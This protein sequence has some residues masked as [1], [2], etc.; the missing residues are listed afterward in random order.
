VTA[1]GFSFAGSFPTPA[2][3]GVVLSGT[4]LIPGTGGTFRR[5]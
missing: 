4:R 5:R 1:S 2:E 3:G